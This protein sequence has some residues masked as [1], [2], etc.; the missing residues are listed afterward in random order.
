MANKKISEY[1]ESEFLA[2]ISSLLDRSLKTEEERDATVH[3]IVDAAEHP[4]G[5]DIIFYPPKGTEDTPQG[6]LN[7]IKAWRAANGKPGFK[8]A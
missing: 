4:D 7:R 3:A 6:I 5:T 1:T 2:L 8:K